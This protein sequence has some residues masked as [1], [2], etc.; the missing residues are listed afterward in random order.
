MTYPLLVKLS[1]VLDLP[2]VT[3][4]KTESDYLDYIINSF[5]PRRNSTHWVERNQKQDA[6]DFHARLYACWTSARYAG[7]K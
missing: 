6:Y 3:N 1:V 5:Q 7:T 4:L 2:P